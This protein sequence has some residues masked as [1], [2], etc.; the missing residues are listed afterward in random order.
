M[1][2]PYSNEAHR[3]H[4]QLLND[5]RLGGY[6]SCIASIY[7]DTMRSCSM[8]VACYGAMFYPRTR[9][10]CRKLRATRLSFA[11]GEVENLKKVVNEL[12]SA[13]QEKDRKINEL[14]K[15]VS[16]IYS[17]FGNELVKLSEVF[18]PQC[19][20]YSIG[21]KKRSMGLDMTCMHVRYIPIYT[22]ILR[23]SC[24][25]ALVACIVA[26]HWYVS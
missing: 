15:G 16:L 25:I 21:V 12:M 7:D 22:D 17:L 26:L 24:Q 19:S 10:V 11:D 5:A 9:I 18:P 3:Q 13:G 1:P 6:E 4:C 2:I 14:R 20:M 8:Y 23:I